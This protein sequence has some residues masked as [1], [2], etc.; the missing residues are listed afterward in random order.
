MAPSPPYSNNTTTTRIL[1]APK[2]R[3]YTKPDAA[4]LLQLDLDFEAGLESPPLSPRC[5]YAEASSIPIESRSSTLN[6]P[7][8]TRSIRTRQRHKSIREMIGP[9]TE[10]EFDALPIAVRRKVCANVFFPRP[11]H[12]QNLADGLRWHP[13]TCVDGLGGVAIFHVI[14]ME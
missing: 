9:T 5:L 14:S 1:H 4:S 12:G 10:E 2:S 11:I 8:Q 3:F 6:L 7:H 13:P